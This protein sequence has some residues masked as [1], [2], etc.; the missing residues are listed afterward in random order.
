MKSKR[1][2]LACLGIGGMLMGLAAGVSAVQAHAYCALCIDTCIPY[3]TGGCEIY[4]ATP[5]VQTDT[6]CPPATHTTTQC[7]ITPTTGCYTVYRICTDTFCN[8]LTCEDSSG[9]TTYVYPYIDAA[10]TFSGPDHCV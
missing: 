5:G 6:S 10:P 7:T 4:F 1:V 2:V 3:S 8:G 9:C